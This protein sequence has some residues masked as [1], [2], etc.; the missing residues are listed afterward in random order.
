MQPEPI[1]VSSY[2]AGNFQMSGA[3]TIDIDRLQ[4]MAAGSQWCRVDGGR[5]VASSALVE[6]PSPVV[7][8]MILSGW[9]TSNGKLS[10]PEN[11]RIENF[12]ASPGEWFSPKIII[13]HL[14]GYGYTAARYRQ[15]AQLL[16]DFGFD[17]CRSRRGV[18]GQYWELWLLPYL[19]AAKG[20]LLAAIGERSIPVQRRVDFAVDFL[21]KRVAFGTLDVCYQQAAMTVD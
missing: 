1:R 17:C 21:C 13:Q 8:P 19:E 11:V 16:E 6:P 14:C 20:E 10:R 2:G 9:Q 12:L 7:D 3:S 15:L 18:S 4:G 5:I